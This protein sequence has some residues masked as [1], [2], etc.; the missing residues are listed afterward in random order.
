MANPVR[1][2]LW[3]FF[4]IGLMPVSFAQDFLDPRL[5]IRA[6][7]K[8]P[9]VMGNLAFRKTFGGIY[10]LN[11]SVNGHFFKKLYVGAGG[12][13]AMFNTPDNKIPNSKTLMQVFGGYG[14]V[15]YETFISENTFV[16]AGVNLGQAFVNYI[17]VISK[18]A[19][20]TAA[21]FRYTGR[22]MEPELNFYFMLEDNFA[23]GVN[24]STM[25]MNYRWHPSIAAMADRRTYGSND[26]NG[27]IQSWFS[28]GFGF[29]YGFW[30][31]KK[32]E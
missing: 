11:L 25:L 23:I 17:G 19:S 22:Y 29:Y 6:D 32:L 7:C 31:K 20:K 3:V 10:D 28:F 12:K 21:D 30:N 18:D 1:F 8:V 27:V 5:S 15:G 24:L 26:A 16:S 2:F 4:L 9:N 14:K 13:N